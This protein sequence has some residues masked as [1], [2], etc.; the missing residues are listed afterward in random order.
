MADED[1]DQTLAALVG[2]KGDL[3]D[4]LRKQ[5]AAMRP[6][7]AGQV[8]AKEE[9]EQR[10]WKKKA[11][12]RAQISLTDDVKRERCDRKREV[13]MNPFFA[14]GKKDESEDERKERCMKEWT[15]CLREQGLGVPVEEPP[16][17]YLPSVVDEWADTEAVLPSFVPPPS[18]Q[19]VQVPVL[20]D[21][22]PIEGEDLP[23]WA[24]R[25]KTDREAEFQRQREDEEERRRLEEEE[26]E[27][28]EAPV[29]EPPQD[30]VED[31]FLLSAAEE[32]QVGKLRR[33]L[34]AA[35]SM[36]RDAGLQYVYFADDDTLLV[37]S[38]WASNAYR[39]IGTFAEAGSWDD[40]ELRLI[41]SLEAA[42]TVFTTLSG[43]AHGTARYI[44]LYGMALS[45]FLI[46][47]TRRVRTLPESDRA[48][49]E[50][51][52]AE[53]LDAL[54]AIDVDVVGAKATPSMVHYLRAFL[55]LANGETEESEAHARRAAEADDLVVADYAKRLAT[56]RGD[57]ERVR[58]RTGLDASDVFAG[59]ASAPP[60][61]SKF[62]VDDILG[63]EEV[64]TRKDVQALYT[65]VEGTYVSGVT[66]VIDQYRVGAVPPMVVKKSLV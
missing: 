51:S 17:E 11:A 57:Y 63:S 38:L 64:L 36:P 15:D 28:V 22:D 14:F 16:E 59:I 49:Y 8:R 5:L 42:R 32:L 60:P 34:V 35:A 44:A 29:P 40:G 66:R 52:L 41:A 53:A 48:L 65:S 33:E 58:S 10:D 25:G 12:Q 39:L 50:R 4:M 31:L 21:I 26:E 18:E 55:A 3:M 56:F 47:F 1:L 24:M 45:D 7:L 2:A 37:E 9:R 6:D 27:D 19:M 43:V 20:I 30:V 54:E 23:D 46:L 61:P 13:C 62:A